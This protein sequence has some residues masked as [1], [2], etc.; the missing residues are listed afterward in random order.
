MLRSIET[1]LD[2]DIRAVDDDIGHVHDFYF[3]DSTWTIRYLVVDTGNWLPGRRVLLSPE[4][5]AEPDWDQQILPVRHTREAIENSPH[6]STKQPV[7]RQQQTALHN[8]YQWAPYW[9]PPG[10]PTR[11]IPPQVAVPAQ[12]TAVDVEETQADVAETGDPHLRSIDEVTGY[13]IDALD[14]D[15]GHVEDFIIDDSTW[16]MRYLVIDTRN[17]LPGRKVMVATSWIHEVRWADAKLA[18]DLSKEAIQNSPE[19]DPG[20]PI[21]REY[22]EALYDYYGRPRYW[23]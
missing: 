10:I 19:F 22:E 6:I 17:W 23:Q 12:K 18:V 3:D 13:H 20:Q 9:N 11:P 7:S 16:L 5:I 14:D 15:I 1:I 8:Y 4:A 2:Y 21:N